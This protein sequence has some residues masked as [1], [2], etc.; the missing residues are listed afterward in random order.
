MAKFAITEINKNP[1]QLKKQKFKR[2]AAKELPLP[3]QTPVIAT[4]G[5]VRSLN[6]TQESS[7]A[8]IKSSQAQVQ[9]SQPKEKRKLYP[10]SPIKCRAS[11][12]GKTTACEARRVRYVTLRNGT[13]IEKRV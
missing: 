9:S 13:Y 12:T 2:K 4:R 11:S 5:A 3:P 10:V 1:L 7:Q 8:K 6:S